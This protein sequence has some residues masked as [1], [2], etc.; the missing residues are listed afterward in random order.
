MTDPLPQI[1]ENNYVLCTI[2]EF[3]AKAPEG[4]RLR[5][6]RDCC[7]S[8]PLIIWDPEDGPEGF[9]I[10]GSTVDELNEAF[11]DHILF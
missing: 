1:T 2:S 10:T 11:N 4:H 9:M 7:L 5:Y 8:D 3:L 6:S